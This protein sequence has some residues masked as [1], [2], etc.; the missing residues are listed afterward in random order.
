MLF[1]VVEKQPEIFESILQN[2]NFN[3]YKS[4][5]EVEKIKKKPNW[6]GSIYEMLG[7]EIQTD[8]YYDDKIFR[9]QFLN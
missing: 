8:T 3:L 1:K 7:Y 2:V 6:M 5:L 4:N 9:N